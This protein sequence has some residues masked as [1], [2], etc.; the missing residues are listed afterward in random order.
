MIS[1]APIWALVLRHARMYRRDTNILL[2]VLYWPLL[3]IIT[4]GFLGSWIQQ[5][6]M[7]QF[8]NYKVVALL[9]ILLWQIVG[10][11]CN[12]MMFTLTEELWS[13]NVVT[14]FSLPLR[15]TEWICG[16]LL[17]SAIMMSITTATCMFFIALLYD[18]SLWYITPIFLMFA[19][20][21]FFSS[22]WL[23]FTALSILVS[24]GKRGAELGFVIIWFLLPFSGAYYPI[25]ILPAWG[26]TIAAFLPMSYVFQAMRN[27][28]SHQ[29]DPTY[30]MVQG[31]VL[32]M[33][34]ALS[35]VLLFVWCFHHSKKQG[36]ARLAH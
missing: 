1:W 12:I 28:L 10:R 15:M 18:V 4:W 3:D 19:P 14:L 7:T 31:Y 26:Q 35:A 33:V 17:F 20:P 34:Y 21:L 6:H 24:L 5:S 22:I 13:N 11:G 30:C 29:Q 2:G 25:E 36:L 23:G 9:G 32:S 16:S 27:Y 8:Q